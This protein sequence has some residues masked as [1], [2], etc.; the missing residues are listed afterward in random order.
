V[1]HEAGW[2]R[3][4][5]GEQG[6]DHLGPGRQRED[7]NAAGLPWPCTMLPMAPRRRWGTSR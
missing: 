5:C 4:R 3:A 1:I 7:V 6:D 2:D